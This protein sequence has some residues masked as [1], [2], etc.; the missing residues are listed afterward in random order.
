MPDLLGNLLV[1]RQEK[2][3]A[4]MFR[5]LSM[6]FL[7]FLFVG[8][9]VGYFVSRTLYKMPSTVD[10]STTPVEQNSSY[11]GIVT[12]VDPHMYPEDKINYVLLDSSGKEVILLKAK[13]QKLEV[14]EGHMAEVKGKKRPL[15]A[16]KG[17]YLLVDTLVIKN[18]SN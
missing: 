12:Y 3:T 6:I 13:D 11:E 7:V 9:L 4:S 17:E 1:D 14:S 15:T 2:S 16:G 5:S 18:A 10:T 8:L